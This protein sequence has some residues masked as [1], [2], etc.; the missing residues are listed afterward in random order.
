[1]AETLKLEIVTPES[2]IYSED[3]EMVTLPGSEGEAGIYPNHVPLMTQ[4]Q[5][6]EIIVKRG[7]N[8]EI[9]AIGEGF[10]EVTGDHVAILTDNAANS[11]DIDEATAEEAR[12]KAEQRLAESGDI[13]EEEARALNQAILYSEAQIKAKRRKRS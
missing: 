10:A 5:A 6:G 7:G 9:V 1:M 4:V 2:K 11:D 3:V 8:E 13:S 12:T